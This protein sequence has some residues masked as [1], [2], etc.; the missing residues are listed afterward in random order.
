MR[1]TK[2]YNNTV[3]GSRK[4]TFPEEKEI[5]CTKA[6]SKEA[7]CKTMAVIMRNKANRKVQKR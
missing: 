5:N 2:R 3:K 1:K 7:Q 6:G 4:L